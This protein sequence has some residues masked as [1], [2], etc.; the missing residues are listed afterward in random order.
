MY[1][2]SSE[3][4]NEQPRT[5]HRGRFVIDDITRDIRKKNRMSTFYRRLITEIPILLFG[6][7]LIIGNFVLFF[8][9]NKKISE[10]RISGELSESLAS[11]Y[12]LLAGLG[13]G[14]LISVF[15]VI[16]RQIV[17]L[18]MD[19]EN[20]RFESSLDNSRLP[21]LFM[22]NFAM[23]YINLF[24]YAFYL[25]D[26]AVLRGN[27][28]SLFFI[29]NLS[30]LS[31][32]YGLPIITYIFKKWLARSKLR[33]SRLARKAAFLKERDIDPGRD[34]LTLD[35]LMLDEVLTHERELYRWQ[36]IEQETL[37][38]APPLMTT[39]W[40]N[41]LFQ[42]GFITF[43][44]ITFPLAPLFACIFNYLE[45][46]L[47]VFVHLRVCKRAPVKELKTVGTWNYLL[48]L[49]TYA[50]LIVNA[51]LFA[52][53]SR[54]FS[55]LVSKQNELTKVELLI[56]VEH[57][58][59][60]LKVIVSLL[61]SDTPKWV[62]REMKRRT[63]KRSIYNLSEK[64]R[65]FMMKTGKRDSFLSHVPL[66]STIADKLNKL[67]KPDTKK[68]PGS[69]GGTTQPRP[70]I[71]QDMINADKKNENN[72]SNDYNVYN[73]GIQKKQVKEKNDYNLDDV[74]ELE[75]RG[76]YLG[77]SGEN[78]GGDMNPAN[79]LNHK[80][81]NLIDQEMM[82]DQMLMDSDVFTT[83]FPR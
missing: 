81:K 35:R 73:P 20:H 12:A 36:F 45:T 19:W 41:Q 24:F 62:Q 55:Y 23:H 64:Q 56:I 6:V 44:S 32:T 34:H 54:G 49:M 43:F 8:F 70:D 5:R 82:E 74:F 39:V 25:R 18:V 30:H 16:Y 15:G 72:D 59:L 40:Q 75:K 57:V 71:F 10:M 46:V 13:N 80:G 2:T 61:I 27:F 29:R 58:V 1:D 3:A 14:I 65:L 33:K 50:S 31:I 42:F 63:H 21:K 17:E 28:I 51:A 66:L 48:T 79:V 77:E 38:P 78:Q 47:F 68:D 67:G 60:T 83:Q 69:G 7:A 22:F 9:L 76:R 53:T 52:F 26:F 11:K 37:R 4:L